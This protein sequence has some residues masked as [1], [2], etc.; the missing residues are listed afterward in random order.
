KPTE[1]VSFVKVPDLLLKN[2]NIFILIVRGN[3]LVSEC[4]KNDDYILIESKNKAQSGE[5]TIIRTEGE[6]VIVRKLFKKDDY[7]ML[8]SPDQNIEPQ[9]KKEEELNILGAI[10]GVYR[11]Y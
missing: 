8:Q 3:F 7:F 11:Q 5:I 2:N 6:N 1:N 9:I 4:I 10:K